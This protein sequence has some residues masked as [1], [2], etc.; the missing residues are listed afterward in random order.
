MANNNKNIETKDMP[1]KLIMQEV[2]PKNAYKPNVTKRDLYQHYQVAD[3]E[4]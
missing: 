2:W 1:E 4:F 3:D